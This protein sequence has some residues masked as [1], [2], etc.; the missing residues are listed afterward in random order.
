MSSREVEGVDRRAFLTAATAAMVAPNWCRA[1]GAAAPGRLMY[2]AGG[3]TWI[4]AADGSGERCLEFDAPGQA[5]WQPA[6]FFSDG[7]LVLL[8][9]EPRRDGPGRPFD[10]YY[11][12]T[13]THLWRYDLDSGQ[14]DELCTRERLAPF[15]TPALVLDDEQL[16]VQVIRD[17]VGQ[18]MRMALDGTG[19]EPFTQPGEGLPYGLSL[20]PDRQRVAYHLASPQGYQIWTADRQGQDRRLVAADPRHLYFGTAW[21]PDGDWVVYQDCLYQDDPGHDWS[22]LC[23]GRP[24]GGGHRLLSQG[25]SLW[26]AAT[27]GDAKHR[28]GGSNQPCCGADGQ[29]LAS[30]RSA[31]A[32]PAWQYQPN[33][34]DV[35]H[36]NRDYHPELAEGGTSI[37][38]FRVSDGGLTR[39]TP[40]Q[41]GVWDFRAAPSPDGAWIAFCRARVGASPELWLM[42]PDGSEPRRLTRG[43][44]EAGVDHPRW[45]PAPGV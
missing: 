10:Q 33:R 44:G 1:A 29:I 15:Y 31:A 11:H 20:S 43:P 38:S 23:V 6:G 26:F 39:L 19:A 37:G 36:F 35:D 4:I 34:V 32:R 7:R 3:K 18:I 24:E 30:V 9:M 22:D 42:R 8:S 27:Y 13:P 17:G 21:S 45:L 40:A 12:Q 41:A 25:Q 28:G 2:T 5:T 14:L 16:L